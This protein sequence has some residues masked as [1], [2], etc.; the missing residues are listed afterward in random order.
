MKYARKRLTKSER[1]A[2]VILQLKRGDGSPAID[3]DVAK[4]MT[5]DEIIAAFEAS[6]QFDHTV[7]VAIGGNNHPTNVTAIDPAEH[8]AKT[9]KTDVPQ[10]AKTKRI[11]AAE[12]AFRGRVLAKSGQ[13]VEENATKRSRW[14]SRK[15]TLAAKKDRYVY[16]WSVGKY[17][18]SSREKEHQKPCR[19]GARPRRK[20]SE[21][22]ASVSAGVDTAGHTAASDGPA[23]G[24][25]QSRRLSTR[26]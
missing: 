23:T 3:R 22:N 24:P 21:G 10:I 6:V 16:D 2:S 19:A 4:T 8:R 7:P 18:E 25:S 9:A 14:P 11:A 15:F 1:Y 13:S 17:V 26:E 5:A 12:A 20:R